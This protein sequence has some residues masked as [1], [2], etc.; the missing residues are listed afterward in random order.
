[1]AYMRH[2][3]Q[4]FTQCIS[5][6]PPLRCS[7]QCAPEGLSCFSKLAYRPVL[8]VRHLCAHRCTSHCAACCKPHHCVP[9][10]AYHPVPIAAHPPVFHTC[11]SL[12]TA[13]LHMN[14]CA[15]WLMFMDNHLLVVLYA[16]LLNLI[17]MGAGGSVCMGSCISAKL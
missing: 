5:A 2:I 6:G 14:R 17:K 15:F 8:P 9:F 10:A 11:T 7:N 16:S 13:L 12:S 3:P 4:G 1:M